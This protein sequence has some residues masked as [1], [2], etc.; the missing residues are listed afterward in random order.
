MDKNFP[1]KTT[2]IEN[3]AQKKCV[4]YIFCNN[5]LLYVCSCSIKKYP[6]DFRFVLEGGMYDFNADSRLLSIHHLRSVKLVCT[7]LEMSP[8]SAAKP[9]VQGSTKE[10]IDP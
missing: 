7:S 1:D 10:M 8:T 4:N 6:I 3:C 5:Q 9:T 2:V